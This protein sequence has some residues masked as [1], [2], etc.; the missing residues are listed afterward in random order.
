MTADDPREH[1]DRAPP[2]ASSA[3]VL[4]RPDGGW[5]VGVGPG[6]VVLRRV[7]GKDAGAG[8]VLGVA[9]A[10]VPPAL[11]PGQQA[12]ADAATPGCAVLGAGPLASRLRRT[13]RGGDPDPEGRVQVVV[14]HHVVPPDVG[15]A[16]SRSGPPTVPV[17]VQGRRALVGPVVG[18]G[19]PCLHCL[20]LHRRDRDAAWPQLAT[21]LGHPLEQL[22]PVDLPEAMARAVEG[23]VLLLVSAVLAGRPVAMGLAYELGPGAPHVVVRRWAVHPG[24]RWH[25]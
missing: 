10:G 21:A 8:E 3:P 11:P 16:V 1:E 12:D 15:L 9:L 22:G 20:D 23:V 4:P 13:L 24:C 6:A 19:G 18:L 2:R 17:V 5:Q 7:D 14:H 25:P